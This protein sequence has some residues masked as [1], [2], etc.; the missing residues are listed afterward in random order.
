MR[1]LN[2][3]SRIILNFKKLIYDS[4]EYVMFKLDTVQSKNYQL[5]PEVKKFESIEGIPSSIRRLLNL[6]PLVNPLYYRIKLKQAYLLCLIINSKIV[7][8][9]FIQSWK[10]FKRKFGWLYNDG[11][12]LGPYWTDENM[13]GQG[14]YGRLLKH[15][16]GLSANKLPLI[17]YTNPKNLSSKRGIEKAGFDFC[18]VYRISLLFRIFQSHKQISSEG[19]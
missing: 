19:V 13:R 4:E 14:Y 6:F 8:Y 10:P 1:L 16:I 9:G 2:Y 3:I 15:S 18:G 7:S 17:I 5:D 12:M 11:T